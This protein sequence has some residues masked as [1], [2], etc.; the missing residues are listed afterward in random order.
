MLKRVPTGTA[1]SRCVGICEFCLRTNHAQGIFHSTRSVCLNIDWTGGTFRL[2]AV[3]VLKNHPGNYT[4]VS[5]DFKHNTCAIVHCIQLSVER[6]QLG[7]LHS[8]PLKRDTNVSSKRSA[9]AQAKHN[10]LVFDF[11]MSHASIFVLFD[12]C[13]PHEEIVFGKIYILIEHLT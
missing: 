8:P 4:V 3:A 11:W 12:V 5:D 10:K 1:E 6:N 9:R 7:K 13:A 2:L